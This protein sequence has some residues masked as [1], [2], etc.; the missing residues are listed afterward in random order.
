V[1][2]NAVPTVETVKLLVDELA[3]LKI[4]Q[5]QLYIEHTFAY[6]GHEEVW[7]NSSPYTGTFIAAASHARVCRS[8]M[9]SY[10]AQPRTLWSWTPIAGSASWSWCPTRTAS[11]TSTAGSSTLPTA[12][13]QR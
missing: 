8:L 5:L 7:R 11:V 10:C 1:R 4:N 12:S 2:V 6:A 9:R 13:T 3:S